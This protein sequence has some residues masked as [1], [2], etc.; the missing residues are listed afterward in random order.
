MLGEHDCAGTPK[1][2]LI[3]VEIRAL[4]ESGQGPA[5]RQMEATDH[6]LAQIAGAEEAGATVQM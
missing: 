5:A 6:V 1:T 4:Q 2:E 3:C